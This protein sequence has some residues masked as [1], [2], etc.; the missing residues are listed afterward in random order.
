MNL[1]ETRTRFNGGNRVRNASMRVGA[2]Y[3]ETL[4][5]VVLAAS[6]VT[7]C[8][9][10]SPP[11]EPGEA[12]DLVWPQPPDSAR[13]RYRFDIRGP[14]DLG[15]RPGLFRRFLDWV[16]GREAQQLVRP[17]SLATDGEG[18]LWVTDP[19][20]R[21]V[22]IFDAKKM[23]HLSLPQRGDTPLGSPIAVTHDANG[24]AYVTDS[25]RAVIRRFDRSGRALD[26]WGGDVGLTRP[27][28]A[29]FDVSTGTLWV[30][31]TGRHAILGFDDRGQV[32]RT[33]GGR[34]TSLG[35]LNFP[36]HLVVAP[37]GRLI[38]AD[39]LNF[40]LQIFSPRGDALGAIGELGDG[41]GSLS[42]PKGVAI[43][44]DGHV[45]VVDALFDNLQVFDEDGTLL[46]H[47][48]ASGSGPGGFWLPA[49]VHIA[50]GRMIYVADAYNRRI[51][52]FEYLD[53]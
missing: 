6:I 15:I 27:T 18:R 7:A 16:S 36:T 25:A 35:K 29:A 50:E 51:Q 32:V 5:V 40:R 3:A 23:V 31:D 21:R 41:P 33:I 46:L 45:Y 53:E 17:H 48:G 42:K 47:F 19:G 39:T 10:P 11:T 22:H 12:V 1:I 30:V 43:D 4:C 20:A 28:G 52:V 44:K 38:V 8:Q 24:I 34:G 9:S 37:D 26:S 14:L 13:I 2:N 49:G